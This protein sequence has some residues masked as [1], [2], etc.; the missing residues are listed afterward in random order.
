MASCWRY[1]TFALP[2]TETLRPVVADGPTV[3]DRADP[4][5]GAVAV[6]RR[7]RRIER[8]VSGATAVSVGLLGAA[9][10]LA[11]PLLWALVAFL[12]LLALAR[13]PVF[14]TGGRARLRTDTDPEAVRADFAG[15]TPPPL[16]LQWGI[17]DDIRSVGSGAVYEISYLFGLR[18]VE[19]RVD[20]DADAADRVEITGTVDG[21]SW[22]TYTARIEPTGT[23]TE[24]VLDVRS[25]RKFGL[26]RLPQRF[27]ARRF[28]DAALRAQGYEVLERAD[29]L[30]R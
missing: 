7:Y 28:R 13:V 24:V 6:V 10:Y 27:V 23:G 3:T 9:A 8:L 26:R 15:A 1:G 5:D 4:P 29:S 21:R 20:T 11:L 22:G 17:A 19:M 30:S 14:R 2:T 12:A 25:D 16:A 18:S